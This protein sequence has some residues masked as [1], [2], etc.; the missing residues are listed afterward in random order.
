V[1]ELATIT[2]E[3]GLKI[4]L[5]YEPIAGQLFTEAYGEPTMEVGPFF[6]SEQAAIDYIQDSW[7]HGWNLTWLE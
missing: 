7:G 2:N 3:A 6:A 5:S 1:K 4:T